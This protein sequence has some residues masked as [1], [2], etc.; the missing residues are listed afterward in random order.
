MN[1]VPPRVTEF[2]NYC[3]ELAVYNSI[4]FKGDRVIVPRDLRSETMKRVHSSHQGEQACLRRARDALFW[5]DMIQQIREEV[6]KCGVCAEYAV[7]QPKEIA[8]KTLEYCCSRSVLSW[9]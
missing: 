1:E 9:T 2:W 8:I 3:D 5:P 4:L 6:S 7:S